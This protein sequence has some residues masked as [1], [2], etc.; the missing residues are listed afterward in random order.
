MGPCSYLLSYVPRIFHTL[1]VFLGK[2]ICF[3][4][5][6]KSNQLPWGRQRIGN[7]LSS[8]QLRSTV[9]L[10]RNKGR[11]R[12]QSQLDIFCLDDRKKDSLHDPLLTG[13]NACAIMLIVLTPTSARGHR[14]CLILCLL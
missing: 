8:V 10:L 13:H 6:N 7:T 5:S 14:P 2:K 3:V 11:I 1:S 4:L 12:N 9:Q